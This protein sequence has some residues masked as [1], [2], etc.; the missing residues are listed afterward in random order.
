MKNIF[1]GAPY[2]P[3]NAASGSRLA[4]ANDLVRRTLA[5]HGL[6]SG[7][8]GTQAS[9]SQWAMPTSLNP[10][11]RLQ[12]GLGGLAATG[13]TKMCGA[14][15]SDTV[16][17]GAHFR[18]EQ[19]ECAAGNRSYRTYVPASAEKGV[20][21]IVL[22]LH[23]CTQT[24]EDFAAGTDMNTLA[25]QHGFVVIYAQQSRG[26]NAQSCWN[27]FS[28]GDQ[29]RD[30]GE[31]AILAGLT[32]RVMAEHDVP[33]DRVFVAGLSAGAAMAVI[34]GETY[35]DLFSAIGVHSGLPFGSAKDVQSAFAAMGGRNRSD[36][37]TSGVPSPLRTIIFH[38]TTDQ[39]VHPANGEQIAEDSAASC[40]EPTVEIV[41][42]GSVAGRSFDRRITTTLNGLSKL[43]HWIVDGLGHAWS[44]GSP[45]GSYTDP[46]GPSASQEMIRF[47]FD[48]PERAM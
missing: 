38:G 26:S 37:A 48:M 34:L 31:P 21:G 13:G 46:T 17:S 42:K 33:S 43:E 12:A 25:E 2:Q 27:W 15:T 8:D 3:G 47:F 23:G 40:S 10:L 7:F 36:T 22:M 6:T 28:R 16:P 24:A 30:R 18:Q 19:Y 1:A 5:Q 11:S 14:A 39:T 44:G 35:P 20:T 29:R 32:S 4:A 45:E 41:E 9:G